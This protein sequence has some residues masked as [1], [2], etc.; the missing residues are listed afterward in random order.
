MT[1][2]RKVAKFLSEIDFGKE[3]PSR[4][5]F[6]N[7]LQK[8][9]EGLEPRLGRLREE[10]GRAYGAHFTMTGSGSAY[11]A[12]FDSADSPEGWL[13]V[14]RMRCRV[15]TVRTLDFDQS[16]AQLGERRGDH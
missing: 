11:F 15:C 9:A 13:Q 16:A 5:T 14:D 6:F 3:G 2:P 7:R 1:P 4:A 8:A 10:A 12:P